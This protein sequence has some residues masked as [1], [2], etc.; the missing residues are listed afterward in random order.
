MNKYV[1]VTGGAGYIGSH[2]VVALQQQ[3]YTPV[4][5]DDFRNANKIVL[6]GL[7]S[8]LG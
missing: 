1:L 8:I 4:I 3:G 5:A 2:T 6:G 7:R